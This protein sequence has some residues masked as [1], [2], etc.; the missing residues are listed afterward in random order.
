ML[1]YGL[2]D[3]LKSHFVY[4]QTQDFDPMFQEF[5]FYKQLYYIK[6]FT[7]ILGGKPLRARHKHNI[8]CHMLELNLH[9]PSLFA[10][11]HP[12]YT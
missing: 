6:K 11:F 7:L 10:D 1:M 12:L 2:K 3:F 5:L 4:D 9:T 8:T